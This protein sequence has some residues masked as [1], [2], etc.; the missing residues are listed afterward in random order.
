[1]RGKVRDMCAPKGRVEGQA[2]GML[3][4]RAGG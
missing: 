4:R 1:M 3:S 2:E